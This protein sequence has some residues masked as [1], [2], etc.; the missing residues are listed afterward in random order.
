MVQ[1]PA[2]YVRSTFKRSSS[3]RNVSELVPFLNEPGKDLWIGAQ[4]QATIRI[5]K[6]IH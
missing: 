5:P 1:Q 4:V 3:E 6:A 2:R